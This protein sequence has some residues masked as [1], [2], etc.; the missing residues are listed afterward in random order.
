MKPSTKFCRICGSSR[1]EPLYFSEG[2]S[3][4]SVRVVVDIPIK[5]YL[6]ME[7][8]HA[9]KEALHN[10]SD[11]YDSQYRISLQSDDFDQLYDVVDGKC[12]YRTDFQAEVVLNLAQI[13]AGAKILD[14]GAGK[15][16]TLQ[17]I[18]TTRPDLVPFVFDVSD[19]YRVF[20]D[21]F[22]P[23]KQQASYILPESWSG[24][25][26]LLTAHFVLEHA[27]EPSKLLSSISNLLIP[28]GVFFFSVPNSLTNPGDLLAVDHI[29]HFSD[30]SIKVALANANFSLVSIDKNIFRG[31]I[32]CVAMKNGTSVPSVIDDDCKFISQMKEIASFWGKFENK[33][34]DSLKVHSD[35]PAAIFGA[36]IYGSY[37]ALK[38]KDKCLCKC[39]LD[40]SRH[41]ANSTHMGLPVLPPADI[42]DDI[43]VIYAGLNPKIARSVLESLE[44]SKPL[45]VVFFDDINCECI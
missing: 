20:W 17:K 5:V 8:F 42:P 6:C 45:R 43:K 34:L 21:K 4:T 16:S 44:K 26:S 28:G 25:F 12:V 10:T 35:E 9:Q 19:S 37:I 15:A 39:F 41:L 18:I 29:N 1:I 32:V 13:P 14:Y 31:T 23:K 33:L 36:G 11:Y 27:E 38:I 22:V 30:R 3:I 7:C 40:N 2:Q 24:Y